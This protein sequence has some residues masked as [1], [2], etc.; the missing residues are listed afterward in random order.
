VALLQQ[1][2][3]IGPGAADFVLQAYQSVVHD[4]RVDGGTGD[5]QTDRSVG[6]IRHSVF[7]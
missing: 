3:N 6:N 5:Q 7:A 1:N 4:D 2:V